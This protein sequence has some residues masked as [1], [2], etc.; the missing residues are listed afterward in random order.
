MKLIFL[1]GAPAA[2]KLTTAKALLL[3]VPGRLFD[4]HAAIDIARSV[5]DFGAPGFWEL[6]QTVRASVLCAA[7]ANGVALLVTTFVYVEPDDLPTLERFE[8]I[9][10][11]HG[12]QVLPVFLQCSTAEII[13]RV[14]NADRVER[15]KMASE[16]GV[17]AFLASCKVTPVPRSNCLVVDCEIGS[18]EANA[19]QIIQHFDLA[20]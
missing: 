11:R 8:S 2:G 1:H 4:N 9:V 12:G 5:F 10:Q 18:A 16:Q 20:G 7:A 6:V 17:R 3:S 15:G 19:R 14:G 13:R